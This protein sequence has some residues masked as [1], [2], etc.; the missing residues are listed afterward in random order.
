MAD[1]A[2]VLDDVEI[3]LAATSFGD[4]VRQSDYR[5]YAA[6]VQSTHAHIVFAPL[7]DPIDNVIAKM[8]YRSASSVLQL[9]RN[10]RRPAPRSLWTDGRF[11]VF[12]FDRP[13]LHNVIA[14]VR[15]HNRLRGLPDDP[16]P[17]IEPL[18]DV[19]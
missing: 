14:Y 9:R 8:K 13:H 10:M 4:T 17:W 5:V 6:T 18:H 2:V 19:E 12:V 3:M 15:H 1:D 16:Y 7:P 11:P